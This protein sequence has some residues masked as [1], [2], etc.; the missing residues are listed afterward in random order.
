MVPRPAVV[1]TLFSG[2]VNAAIWVKEASGVKSDTSLR[3]KLRV[4]KFVSEERGPRFWTWLEV[5]KRLMRLVLCARAARSLMRLVSN[6]SQF[7]FEAPARGEMSPILFMAKPAEYK[8]VISVA[9]V[10]FVK[11]SPAT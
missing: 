10:R 7:R 4:D 5:K 8:F 3:P 1:R 6:S 9:K 11:P 2:K